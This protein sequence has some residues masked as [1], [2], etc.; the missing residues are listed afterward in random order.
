MRRFFLLEK[1][2]LQEHVEKDFS[3]SKVLLLLV[4]GNFLLIWYEDDI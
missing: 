2:W 3:S 1:V 4:G